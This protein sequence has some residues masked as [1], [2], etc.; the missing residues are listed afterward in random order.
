MSTQP[1]STPPEPKATWEDTSEHV[2]RARALSTMMLEVFGNMS[3]SAPADSHA[4]CNV[5][6]RVT[7]SLT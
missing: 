3:T 5:T 2:W 1:F 6:K 7:T 4:T